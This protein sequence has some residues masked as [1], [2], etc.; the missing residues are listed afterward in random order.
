MKVA[1]GC[2]RSCGNPTPSCRGSAVSR[3][4]GCIVSVKR[5]SLAPYFKK[6][7]LEVATPRPGIKWFVVDGGPINVIESTGAAM[8]EALAGDL[9]A[10]GIRLGFANLRTEV[11]R[12][13]ARR[14]STRGR[15]RCACRRRAG[16]VLMRKPDARKAWNLRVHPGGPVRHQGQLC[17][18][19]AQGWPRRAARRGAHLLWRHRGHPLRGPSPRCFLRRWLVSVLVVGSALQSRRYSVVELITFL[20]LELAIGTQ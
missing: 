14:S 2:G 16:I 7:V 12:R 13:S 1:Q 9:R 10:R 5:E 19:H 20:L 11:S 3:C 6:R 17:Q 8:L 18:A 15:N 4:R